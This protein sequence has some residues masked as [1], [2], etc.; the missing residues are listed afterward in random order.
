[1]TIPFW[2]MQSIGNDFPIVHLSDVVGQNLPALAIKLT[3]RRLSVGGDGLLVVGMEEGDVRL[4]MFN[5]DGTEDFCG[6]GLRCAAQ[7]AA[8]QGWVGDQFAVRHLDQVVRSTL[9]EGKVQSVFGPA[10]FDPAKVPHLYVGEAF[11]RTI[12]SGL[13]GGYPLSLFGSAL[14]TG[15]THVVIP[16]GSLPDNS[17]FFSVAPLI[18]NDEHFPQRT[19]VIWAQETAPM[20]LKI[21]I[22]ERGVGETMGCGT[23]SMA[24]AVNYL[25]LKNAIAPVPAGYSVEVT[26]PGGVVTVKTSS[27]F[28]N[29]TLEGV[30]KTVFTG[31][32]AV[33]DVTIL[34][35]ENAKVSSST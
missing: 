29:L 4:R 11:D 16:T 19:S 33:P 25:R 10:S 13:V 30:A 15:S 1:M 31:T 24:A 27:W 7:H 2:K 3:N 34:P 8:D 9:V 12:W 20:K 23:G 28:G 6:N 5:P 22:W 17:S 21:R 32:V 26:N 35:A 18:E 14:S